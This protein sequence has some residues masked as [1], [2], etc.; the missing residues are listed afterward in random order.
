[1]LAQ[2][3]DALGK[4]ESIEPVR[5]KTRYTFLSA[6]AALPPQRGNDAA[7]WSAERANHGERPVRHRLRAV[8][9]LS[10]AGGLAVGA[11]AGYWTGSMDRT[12]TPYG[13]PANHAEVQQSFQVGGAATGATFGPGGVLAVGTAR[14]SVALLNVR[15][16]QHKRVMLESGGAGPVTRTVFSPKGTVLAVGSDDGTV[17]LWLNATQQPQL[18]AATLKMRED[19]MYGGAVNDLA[20]SPDGKIL[21]VASS[22]SMVRIW[23]VSHSDRPVPLA[24]PERP[25]SVTRLAYSPDGNILAVGSTDGTVQLWDMTDPKDPQNIDGGRVDADASVTALAFS[26]DRKSLAVGNSR[27]S[28]QLWDV[29]QSAS[30]RY[31]DSSKPVGYT[32]DVTFNGPGYILAASN[33]DGTVRLW[34]GL[35]DLMDPRLLTRKTN[36]GELSSVTFADSDNTLAVTGTDGSVQL[37]TA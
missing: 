6:L 19:G 33:S 12:A 22:T 30:P 21:A 36:Q 26:A 27:G 31:V 37:W 34:E 7:C 25:H 23:D 5:T 13:L 32:S 8:S 28:V 2:A 1:M 4:P 15:D 3:L 9:L 14:G 29:S 35:D 11:T 16:G 10:L 20:Y 17:R 18:P 24:A